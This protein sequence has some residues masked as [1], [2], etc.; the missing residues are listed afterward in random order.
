MLRTLPARRQV[1]V[2]P[3]AQ[4]SLQRRQSVE[5]VLL[6]FLLLF[7][8]FRMRLIGPVASPCQFS[9]STKAGESPPDIFP[10]DLKSLD[11]FAASSSL[12][13]EIARPIL[14]EGESAAVNESAGSYFGLKSPVSS[15]KS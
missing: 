14:L 13:V 4:I 7:L 2:V 3:V 10:K 11:I 8:T 1:V 9:M 12:A 15:G 5:I 6:V